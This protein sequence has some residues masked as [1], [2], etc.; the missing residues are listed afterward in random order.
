VKVV[1]DRK[2]SIAVF[3][4]ILAFV[5]VA[6]VRLS[7]LALALMFNTFSLSADAF[8]QAFSSPN[9]WIALLFFVAVGLLLAAVVFTISA[10]A[11]PLI[12]DK[13]TD[14]I[15]AMQT[16]YRVVMYN[17]AAM[18]L[19]AGAIIGLTAIGIATAFVGFVVIFPV[20]GYATWH[21]YR[22]L[23]A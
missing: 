13:D 2:L 23:L 14:F 11:I 20:L 10:V 9:G 19:W 4:L 7:V 17:P 5:M 22:A 18:I 15:T 12:V 6:S 21:S 3:S 8:L 1:Y 16:S